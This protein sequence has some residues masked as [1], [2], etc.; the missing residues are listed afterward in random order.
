MSFGDQGKKKQEQGKPLEEEEDEEFISLEQEPKIK[1]IDDKAT[2]SDI[3]DFQE[4][5]KA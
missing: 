2:L 3:Y 5:E 1:K 4:G